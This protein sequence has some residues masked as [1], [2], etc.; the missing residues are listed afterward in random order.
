MH[1][2]DTG[3]IISLKEDIVAAIES[4]SSGSQKRFDRIPLL[5]SSME[6]ESKKLD[7]AIKILKSLSFP[8][9]QQRYL[10]VVEAH[11]V[12]YTWLFET[13]DGFDQCSL[14]KWLAAEDGIFWINGKAGSGKSTFMKFLVNHENTLKHL[15]HWAG[16]SPLVIASFF[17]WRLG[18]DLQKSM[19]GLLRSLL[20]K[21]LQ[22]CPSLIGDLTWLQSSSMTA[23]VGR[24]WS[25]SDLEQAL[26]AMK[27]SDT[28]TK[29]CFFIDGLDEY[30]GFHP[31]VVKTVINMVQSSK[32]KLCVS[33]RSWN[34]FEEAFGNGIYPSLKLQDMTKK[35]IELYA[36]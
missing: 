24:R 31:D 21:I 18:S 9:M 22:E 35:D 2:S 26:T 23:A 11:S 33:S 19:E 32:I 15:K 8:E 6:E 10:N 16:E 30:N 13:V 36:H 4:S 25:L 5:L 28:S 17:Y 27:R 1:I 14:V 20:F 29:F 3:Q 12:T 34:V 7:R